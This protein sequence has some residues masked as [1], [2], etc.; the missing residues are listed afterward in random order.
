V[1]DEYAFLH[2]TFQE[3][4]AAAH[5]ITL[6]AGELDELLDRAFRSASRFIVLEFIAGLGERTAKR[7]QE[8]AAEWLQTPDRFQQVLLRVARLAAAGRWPQD[9]SG[10]IGRALRD[11]LWREIET[12]DDMEFTQAA[13]DVFVQ[14]DAHNLCRRARQAQNL[15][16]WVLNCMVE[17]LPPSVA[18]GESLD[19]LLEAEWRDYAGFDLRGGATNE[20][21]ER[22]RATL[23]DAS[24]DAADRLEAVKHAGAARDGGAVPAL[25]KIVADHAED[26]EVR[27]QAIDSLAAIGG[28]A[29][30]DGLIDLIFREDRTHVESVRMAAATLRNVD[31][32]RGAL[33][34]P[35]RDRIL[36]RLAALPPDDWRIEHGLTALE[37]HP[38]R[39]G[40]A[41]IGEF[42]LSRDFPT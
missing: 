26:P 41:I 38:I 8:R 30:T 11:E 32:S 29:G 12:N 9:D 36:R 25:L 10:G 15:S 2:A 28:R 42:A 16:T 5:A 34:P 24:A 40:A 20:E 7:C 35:G 1:F 6:R 18:R 39:D 4:F 23:V 13:V 17:S 33:D 27:Q 3:Y 21:V 22:I 14:L 31:A 37:G 19:E